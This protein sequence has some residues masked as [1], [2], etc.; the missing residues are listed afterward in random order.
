MNQFFA[1]VMLLALLSVGATGQA[2]RPRSSRIITGTTFPYGTCEVGDEW[3]DTS[4]APAQ[5]RNCLTAGTWSVV[6]VLS[7]D[8]S[9]SN[10]ITGSSQTVQIA[11]SGFRGV[12]V[13][14]TGTWSGTLVAEL[15]MDGGSSWIAAQFY[16]PVTKA[17][18]SSTTA[19][20]TSS[21]VVTGGASHIR[22][23][24][25]SWTSG[26]ATIA[27]RSTEA[28]TPIVD[29]SLNTQ[30]ISAASLPLPSGASTSAN[31]TNGTQQSNVTKAIPTAL[32]TLQN[33][34]TANGNGTALDVSGY[35]SVSFVV[36]GTYDATIFFEGSVDGIDWAQLSVLRWDSGGQWANSI[37]GETGTYVTMIGSLL[38][39][40][41]RVRDYASGSVTVRATASL[42]MSPISNGLELVHSAL[43]TNAAIEGGGNLTAIVAN[44]TNSAQKTQ[45]VDG[46]G[47]VLGSTS[48][49][50][51]VNIKS[52]N[53]TTIT[54]T[55]GTGTNLHTVVDSGAVNA[56]LQAGSALVG[57]VGIDQTTPG[58]TN[59]VTV[60]SDVVHTIVD[61]GAVTVSDG[62]GALNVIVDSGTTAVTQAT[63]ANLNAQ[64]V[65]AAASGASKAGNPV[66]T[67]GVFNTTQPTVTNGQ[68]VE[69]QFTARGAQIVATGTETFNTTINAALPAGA[70]VIGHVINDSGSTTAVTGNVTVVQP[71]G[72]NLHAVLDANSGVDIG[73]LTANQSVNV[74][75]INGVTATMG[76]GASGTGVQRVT[77]ANDS[78]G[79]VAL[80]A[81][82]NTIG[83]LTA[84]QSVNTAQ[85]NGAT[86]LMGNGTTGTGSPR[87][88]IASDNTA[89]S[90]P[91]LAQPVP[92]T[93]NGA[94]TC[95]VQS[96]ASTNATNCKNGAGLVYGLEVINTTST[97]YFLRLYNLSTSP[98]CSS[99]TGFVRTIP[100]PHASG[101]GAGIANFYTV[102]ETY[103]TGIGFCLTG[104]GGST[105]NTN[106][107]TGIYLTLHY[108]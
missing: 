78:T 58:T 71:T 22:I 63:A 100:I 7:P 96:G 74:A 25:S 2:T 103:G 59:K 101:A 85:I 27:L 73:K 92:G 29:G 20:I 80:A 24:S 16:E 53:P 5:T 67:G 18:S 21:I 88:T 55:Q 39:F 46:S 8:G 40:R 44:Q 81:G 106:A 38:Q 43:P 31:Q 65:G 35:T 41:A 30:P 1:A 10:T 77:I 54:A 60:G 6:A 17:F 48:N 69:S 4:V 95:V 93:A 61:S 14:I 23:R 82:S 47:N 79:Q 9:A 97:I 66:Q 86:P 49:A 84:N 26:T 42:A 76:N 45:V 90:N 108:K 91:W 56:T 33:A 68:A 64:V 19:N 105:D 34:A 98:T 70:N 75:Q 11:L 72:T 87:V 52:G 57:K 107:A 89:N 104:G 36:S 32:T 99:A 102:G 13:T 62:A 28:S 83:A 3:V 15:S 50:L 51:D 94:S 37:D 12:G